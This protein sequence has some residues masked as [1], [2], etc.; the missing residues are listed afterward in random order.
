[1]VLLFF[2]A[3]VLAQACTS[4]IPLAPGPT[5]Y[6]KDPSPADCGTKLIEDPSTPGP[7][8]NGKIPVILIHGICLMALQCDGSSPLTSD[9]NTYFS[10]LIA[11]LSKYSGVKLYRC[12][13]ASNQYRLYD[14]ARSLRNW[15]DYQIKTNSAFDSQYYLIAHSM[16]GL[17]AR[18]YMNEHDHD[19]GA[20]AG[21]RGGERVIKLI[22]LATP[23]HGT[24]LANGDARV[25][26]FWH[27]WWWK[28]FSAFDCWAWSCLA[29]EQNRAD[30]RW[31]NYDGRAWDVPYNVGY[32]RNDWLRALPHTYDKLIVAYYG[33]I[34]NSGLV[35]YY[36]ADGP[37][38]LI[39]GL[40]LTGAADIYSA[41]G[42]ITQRIMSRN[43]SESNAINWVA[44][45]AVVPIESAEFDGA[46]VRTV[47]CSGRNHNEDETKLQM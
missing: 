22:T 34:G 21:R 13:Y 28:E 35:Y 45:D 26:S 44:N 9:L 17:V 23:H 42:V 39:G 31:D 1:M 46:N 38:D 6:V 12:Q 37:F 19:T 3:T 8:A 41:V 11:Y 15:L 20:Y 30:L 29:T 18:S 25:S 24:P 36:G 10:D 4:L 16:G 14:I 5:P 43:F 32:E 33:Y 47:S 2:S 27:P 40:F 7:I